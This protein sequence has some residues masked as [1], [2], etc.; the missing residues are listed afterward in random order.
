MIVTDT[1]I[2]H[3]EVRDAEAILSIYAPYIEQT[4][5]T[6][7][8]CVPSL[9]AF[10][11][12]MKGIVGKYPY[13]VAIEHD[14]ITG[15]AYAHRQAERAA[16]QWNAELSVY[17]AQNRRGRGLGRALSEAVIRLLELQGIRNVFSLI[18]LPND[19]SVHMH[20]ALGFRQVGTQ[21][22]A[23]YKLGAWHDVGWFQKQLGDMSK[24]PSDLCDLREVLGKCERSILA[25]AERAAGNLHA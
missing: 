15:Y 5:F 18:T 6:F 10:E 7:E 23:G 9:T 4:S 21:Y 20:K 8:T 14:Q 25:D 24:A 19:A 2:R 13:L 12:R 11:E 22:Q 1:R 16:Y 17:V 3:A